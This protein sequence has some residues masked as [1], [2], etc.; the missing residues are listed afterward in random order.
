MNTKQLLV[1]SLIAFGMANN[2]VAMEESPEDRQ[3]RERKAAMQKRFET[4]RALEKQ[5]ELE[6]L[7]AQAATHEPA[8]LTPAPAIQPIVFGP[9]DNNAPAPVADHIADH[10]AD[11]VADH[12]PS[13]EELA[14]DFADKERM[15]NRDLERF[16]APLRNLLAMNDEQRNNAITQAILAGNAGKERL[17]EN[18]RVTVESIEYLRDTYK[19]DP[20]FAPI[21]SAL[22]GETI[23]IALQEQLLENSQDA[24]LWEQAHGL[25][26]DLIMNSADN[27]ITESMR[28]MQT[29]FQNAGQRILTGE[30][31]VEE[32]PAEEPFDQDAFFAQRLLEE[33]NLEANRD[34]DAVVAQMLADEQAQQDAANDAFLAREQQEELQAQDRAAQIAQGEAAARR[35]QEEFNRGNQGAPQR[36]PV[37]APERTQ[38]PSSPAATSGLRPAPAPGPNDP[39]NDPDNTPGPRGPNT[40]RDPQPANA[41][42]AAQPTAKKFDLMEFM[43]SPQFMQGLVAVA[44]VSLVSFIVYKVYDWFTKKKEAAQLKKQEA[45]RKKDFPARSKRRQVKTN[46]FA[47]Q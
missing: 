20:E 9:N 31:R 6:K 28:A 14:R 34:N 44:G 41:Q 43:N 32:V 13:D 36:P 23:L 18:R 7:A 40:P 3:M 16:R 12:G 17:S 22:E 2:V 19:N 15:K 38:L 4:R 46:P 26:E 5:Q 10:V 33:E 24:N 11:H 39:D 25:Y 21:I 42:P 1:L 27:L 47:Q 29:A 45:L 30:A 8:P 37:V 35:L